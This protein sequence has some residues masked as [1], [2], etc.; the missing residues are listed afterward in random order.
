M[1]IQPHHEHGE[2]GNRNV[3]RVGMTRGTTARTPIVHTLTHCIPPD[4]THPPR[5][6]GLARIQRQEPR[7]VRARGP[8]GTPG[9]LV[10]LDASGSGK[11]AANGM[12]PTTIVQS[13]KLDSQ[14]NI[15][16]RAPRQNRAMGTTRIKRVAKSS[17]RDNEGT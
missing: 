4:K 3:H 2:N 10:L 12:N 5:H 15:K 1:G 7:R 8:S 14:P 16:G 17:I 13:R 6:T 9:T 11:L